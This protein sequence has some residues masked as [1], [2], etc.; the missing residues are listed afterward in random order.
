MSTRLPQ[1]RLVVVAA[2]L[3][4]AGGCAARQSTQ[5]ISTTLVRGADGPGGVPWPTAGEPSPPN[6]DRE[7]SEEVKTE[8]SA[9]PRTR[10]VADGAQ[11]LEETDP[12]LRQALAAVQEGPHADALRSVAEEYRR[13]GVFDQAHGYLRKA[14]EIDPSDGATHEALARLWRDWG[15]PAE[16]LPAAYRAVAADPKSAA[17]QNTLGTILFVL[18]QIDPAR[19]RFEQALALDATAAYARNNLCHVALIEGED[20]R[21]RDECAAALA[22]DPGLTAASNNLG[23]VHAAAGR[24]RQATESFMAAAGD[25]AVGQY[26]LGVALLSRGEYARALDAFEAALTKRPSFAL[27]RLRADEARKLG[28]ITTADRKLD[29]GRD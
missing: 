22:L 26:N 12:G 16:G 7:F 18:G 20:A 17:A 9:G 14:L 15:L 24:W 27:A 11:V 2:A 28:G 29:D 5:A 23:L 6:P 13:L 8:L 19:E 21:A 3:G 10:L 1:V 4:L 25:E